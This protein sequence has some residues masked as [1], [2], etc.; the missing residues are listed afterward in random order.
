[1]SP[2]RKF[3]NFNSQFTQSRLSG[4]EFLMPRVIGFVITHFTFHN[5]QN[6]LCWE[7]FSPS[8]KNVF[9]THD[10]NIKK[11]ARNIQIPNAKR[12]MLLDKT[13]CAKKGVC[14]I[15]II[16]STLVFIFSQPQFYFLRS[17]LLHVWLLFII[18][19]VAIL[20]IIL[21]A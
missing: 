15:F 12:Y 9:S 7:H 14:T 21:N 3:C 16:Y 10:E 8:Y 17:F 13:F 20:Y 5:L 19:V 11:I 1:M 4:H 2:K 6:K 18:T